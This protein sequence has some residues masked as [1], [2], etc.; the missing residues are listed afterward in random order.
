MRIALALLVSL[1]ATPAFAAA[2]TFGGVLDGR[3]IVVE[4]TQPSDGGV[5]GRFA[6]LDT[7]GDIPLVPVS[8]QGDTWILHEEAVCGEA[9][10]V[11]DD[12][13]D[14]LEAPVAATWQLTYDANNLVATGTRQGAGKKADVDDLVLDVI[15]WRPLGDD[16][17]ATALSLHEQSFY[18]SFSDGGPLDWT[19]APYEMALLDVPLE[20]GPVRTLGGAEYRDVVDPRT[21]FAFPRVV[22]LPGGESVEPINRILADRHGRMNL[23]A[24]D[25]LAYQYASYGLQSQNSIRGGHLGDYDSELVELTYVSPRLVSWT[26]S[27]SLWCTGAHP[28]NHSDSFTFDTATGEALDMRDIFSAWVPREWGAAPSDI[29]D[30]AVAEAAP[31]EYVWGPSQELIAYVRERL[32]T[33]VLFDDLEM[34]ETCYGEQAL[35]EHLGLRFAPGPSVVFT[36]SGYPHVISVCTADLITVPLSDLRDFLAPAAATYFPELA[37]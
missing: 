5:A 25:C 30:A 10:C 29:V 33:D 24:F 20:E 17:N 37:E 3:Q 14:V 4:I 34:D 12:S 31:A 18:L 16:E 19:T 32:P 36:A 26:Q 9:D 23:S 6:Y 7:G 2:L 28:Y 1:S 27:G 22:S 21:K 35:S 8:N 11:L 15:A 13:G